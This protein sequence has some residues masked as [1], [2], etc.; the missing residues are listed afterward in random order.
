MTTLAQRVAS[1]AAW[2][3]GMKLAYRTLGIIST[4]ILAR[5]LVPEDFGLVAMAVAVFAL[6]DMLNQLGLEQA[7]I[8][9]QD[10]GRAH[11]DT[12]WTVLV[13]FG[14]FNA[15][16]LVLMAPIL[17]GWFGDERLVG[18]VY[19]LALLA[20]L[21]GWQ[22]I[23]IVAFR[24]EL[25]FRK[26]FIFLL[27]KKVVAF[28]V[29]VGLAIALRSYWA[30]V[31]GMLA[32]RMTG[33][34]LSYAMHAYRPRFSLARV[35]DL[36]GFSLGVFFNHM[37]LYVRGR[38]PHFLIGRSMG[39]DGLGI[40]AISR[41]ISNLPSTELQI[42]VMRAVF[43]GYAQIADDP[44]RLR[45]AFLKVQ[46]MLA[47][48]T[49]PAGI[50]VVTLAEPLV[51]LLLGPAWLAAI[52]LMQVLG[53]YG[54]AYVLQGNSGPL[55][56]AIGRPHWFG[57]LM[58]AE[59]L[60][61][62]PLLGVLLFLGY[63]LETAVWAFVVAGVAMIPVAVATVSRML[64][65]PLHALVTV[66]W[67]PA[68]A[69]TAMGLALLWATH[70]MQGVDGAGEAAL[71]LL[72]LVPLGATIYALTLMVLWAVTGRPDGAEARLLN[73]V[74]SHIPAPARARELP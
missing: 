7:L 18:I 54:V 47:L 69:A 59:A 58:F 65:L 46:G 33:L 37:A 52:P 64:E 72:L 1:G 38:G 9:D 16:L 21:Q 3:V 40:Y 39:A 13:L 60:I 15:A 23:G 28:T 73:V 19:A 20:F 8:R 29:T 68:L 49:L 51:H 57:L 50:G 53:L 74:G 27:S 63:G 45:E 4:I 12:A 66:V 26:D 17:G 11:Y 48:V 10:A 71:Q 42:P 22:N 67:R 25:K 32:S 36:T 56:M 43:P 35:R 44:P 2:M 55:F 31:A 41:E 30:L 61:T 70:L 34:V 24:K 5:L 6:V 14:C 62:L